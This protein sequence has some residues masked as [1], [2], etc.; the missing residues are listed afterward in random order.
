MPRLSRTFHLIQDIMNGPYTEEKCD[1]F[2]KYHNASFEILNQKKFHIVIDKRQ[3][4][5]RMYTNLDVAH[6]YIV[7]SYSPIIELYNTYNS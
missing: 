5:I 1:G 2:I 3:K 6:K 7:R 4:T